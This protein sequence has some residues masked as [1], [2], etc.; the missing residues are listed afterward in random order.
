MAFPTYPATSFE[1]AVDLAIF[2][3]NQLGQVINGD[4]TTE[5]ETLNGNIPS[6]RKALVDNFY[7]K[8]P[9]DWAAGQAET[10]F[11]QLRF[12]SNGILSAYYYAPAASTTNPI[13]MSNTPEGDSNWVLYST[14]Q[15]VVP[16][17]VYPWYFDTANGSE[18]VISPPYIFDS[19]IVTINGV[20]QVPGVA[21][22]IQDSKIT[23][24]EPL[25]L[26]PDSG[27]PN[28]FFAYLG[29]VEAG[30]ADYVQSTVLSSN[31]GASLIGEVGS[32]TALRSLIPTRT[33]QKVEVKGYNAGTST[34][35]GKFYYVADTTTA[36]DGGTFFRVD[37]NGGWKRST[38]NIDGLNILHFG[39]I[40]DGVTNDAAAIVRMHNWS[41]ALGST[42]GPGV[43]IPAGKTAVDT[44]D[45]GTAEIPAF[46]I[47]GPQR[48][49]GHLVS[50][51]LIP[52]SKTQ[53]TPMFTF[54]ARRMEVS[55][56]R[57]N[58]T[59]TVQPFFKNTVTRGAFARV[60]SIRADGIGGRAF[61]LV[62]TLDCKFDQ[63]YSYNGKAAFIWVT[64]S[65]LSPGAW[66]HPT[67]IEI[68]NFN[69][70]SHTGEYVVSAI[71][72]GQSMMYN[73]WFDHNENPFDISQG[74]W[75]LD[76]ITMENS[77]NPAGTKYAKLIQIYCRWAQGAG[78]DDTV[79]GYTKDMDLLNGGSGN[80][81]S[82]VTNGYDQGSI[83]MTPQGSKFDSGVSM[84][85]EYSNLILTN[86]TSQPQWYQVGRV[87]TT[88]QGQTWKMKIIG[89]AGWDGTGTSLTRPDS[90]N[91]GGGE[92][93][94]YFESKQPTAD[95][96][97]SGEMHWFAEGSSPI[98]AVKYL[99]YYGYT[100][101]YVQMATY[102]KVASVFLETT[103]VSRLQAG[104]PFWF[105]QDGIA[106]TEV[107]VNA[108]AHI[109]TAVKR[110]A[111]NG[112]G[113]GAYG[114]G[115]DLDSGNIVLNAATV[116]NAAARHL[117][118]SLLGTTFYMPMQDTNQSLR[119]PVY[120]YADLPSPSTNVY[121]IVLCRDTTLAQAMQPLFSNGITW[122]LV[123][124]PSNTSWRP[125]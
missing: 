64:W 39:A 100:T 116:T 53:T 78:L 85:F 95:Y 92:A 7:F 14:Q 94:I 101:V 73:G 42:F 22:T 54:C 123:S 118:V 51:T 60:H 62:D 56:L 24:T 71:R 37:A 104:T 25:G 15:Q 102:C 32:C 20:V 109:A 44:I 108:V 84:E 69:F 113:Y 68:S 99:H 49:Y 29:K 77:T 8:D 86:T 9:I 57:L 52:F 66:D 11:N 33:N 117:P 98:T 21:Y 90:T 122:Y 121:G 55:N 45:L 88:G 74:G 70:N 41:M 72:A 111:I 97:T 65:N 120:S 96:T 47:R 119:I 79:S 76:N 43:I 17:E 59:G 46:K 36:D 93:T 83:N 107:D 30:T 110:W 115:M 75:T 112:G 61:Q 34:G 48:E 1:Q 16:A 18:T 2:S 10:V 89:T 124:D 12:Y 35:G 91:F 13:A 58:G 50:A 38:P 26:D 103:G 125:A 63:V 23:L 28:L 82:W 105:R 31:I 3:S 5:V 80:I 67:A 81:P 114:I 6:V 106:M 19:A 4:A 40:C 87:C 27:K